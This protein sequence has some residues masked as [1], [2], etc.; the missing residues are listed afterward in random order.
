[1]NVII[2]I[3]VLLIKHQTDNSK[4]I[5][6]LIWQFSF[7]Q[8]ALTTRQEAFSQRDVVV[9]ILLQSQLSR[10]PEMKSRRHGDI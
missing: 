6:F 7:R 4:F 1:M 2:S 3:A 8:M 10:F 5:I 9:K